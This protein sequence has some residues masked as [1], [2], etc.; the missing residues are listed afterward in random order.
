MVD[1]N[2]RIN[3][4]CIG[5]ALFPTKG[6]RFPRVDAAL[7]GIAIGKPYFIK[8]KF[9]CEIN[10]TSNNNALFY[11]IAAMQMCGRDGV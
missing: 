1:G 3:I 8:K 9:I 5:I 6:H 10:G 2:E 4:Q 7:P 11:F